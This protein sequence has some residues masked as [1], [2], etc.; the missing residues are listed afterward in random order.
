V[1]PNWSPRR[2]RLRGKHVVVLAAMP[3][4]E[5]VESAI[6]RD[7]ASPLPSSPALETEEAVIS[8]VR[9]IVGD[10]GR[11]TVI[12]PSSLAF[13]ASVVAGEYVVPQLEETP[14]PPS[15]VVSIVV[16]DM[17][18]VDSEFRH[19]AAIGYVSV[20]AGNKRRALVD[21]GKLADA[22]VCAG[23]GSV[24]DVIAF[25]QATNFEAPVFA[26]SATGGASARLSE[27]RDVDVIA[28]ERL[29]DDEAPLPREES[30]RDDRSLEPEIR[31]LPAVALTAQW[32]VERLAEGSSEDR[33]RGRR[34]RKS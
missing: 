21:N 30:T 12:A 24:E 9:A 29:V 25:Q 13:L 11:V 2:D 16:T 17:D 5:R 28:A 1:T 19:L 26:F 18:G 6:A 8:L 14:E 22:L 20:T 31:P 33:F 3:D 23:D 4:A 27:S 10:G 7:G 15:S 34:S 32:I